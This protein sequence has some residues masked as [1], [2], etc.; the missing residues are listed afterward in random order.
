[1]SKA[2]KEILSSQSKFEKVARVAFDSVDL[3][4]SGTID[5]QELEKV[6]IQIATDMGAE[7]P[8]KDDVA[9]VLDHLDKDKSGQIDFNEFQILI[10]DVLEAMLE[11]DQE[12][13]DD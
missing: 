12:Q 2:I 7:A 10:R 1:M 11:A 9:E 4:H 13:D 8:T 5:S 6:M 3:D